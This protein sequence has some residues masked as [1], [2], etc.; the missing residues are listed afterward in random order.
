[1]LYHHPGPEIHDWNL[2]FSKDAFRIIREEIPEWDI[3]AFL[4]S[5][6]SEWCEDFLQSI[7][8]N[9]SSVQLEEEART[10]PLFSFYVQFRTAL[11]AHISSQADPQLSLLPN[12]VG[13]NEWLQKNR[14]ELVRCV[15]LE[16]DLIVPFV[17]DME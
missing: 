10:T 15:D 2:S 8:F 17:P 9:L 11:Q 7:G 1:M 14:E 6:T 5:R 16:T 12:P 13:V 3:N 4:P